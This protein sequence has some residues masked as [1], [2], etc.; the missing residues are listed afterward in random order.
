MCYVLLYFYTILLQGQPHGNQ[1]SLSILQGELED[2]DNS[3]SSDDTDDWGS[4]D[5][6]S[7]SSFQSISPVT[8][9]DELSSDDDIPPSEMSDEESVDGE[10]GQHSETPVGKVEG[11]KI[12]C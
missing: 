1:E 3:S 7:D 10:G 2:F 8:S 12:N 11:Q 9:S 6:D 5:S 4:G